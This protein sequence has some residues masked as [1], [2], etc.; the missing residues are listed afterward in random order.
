[1]LGTQSGL[2]TMGPTEEQDDMPGEELAEPRPTLPEQN[3]R[4]TSRQQAFII[5]YLVDLNATKAA[6]RAGY[7]ASNAGSYGADLLANPIISQR[8]EAGI[9]QRAHR[10]AM[11]QEDILHEMSLLS[12]SSHDHYY[13]DD[14]GQVKLTAS[15]PEGAMRA[16]QAIRRKV[17]TRTD[18]DGSTTKTYEVELKLW[19]KPAPL[20]LMGRHVGL[21]PDKVEHS[22]PG[23]GP[24]E[25][26]TRVER[27]IIDPKKGNS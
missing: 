2:K 10:I 11:K 7:A 16:I 25:T 9:A 21:F 15:A 22:G 4:L 20:K 26:I 19:E 14:E 27:V 18:K 3:D 17:I 8:I 23:G 6:I 24:I 13:I 5:E 1:M 12:H